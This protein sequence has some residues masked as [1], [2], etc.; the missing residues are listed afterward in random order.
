MGQKLVSLIDSEAA[1]VIAEVL[2][3]GLFL[4]PPLTGI[5]WEQFTADAFERLEEA[6][7]ASAFQSNECPSP[8]PFASNELCRLAVY[9]FLTST[10]SLIA[11]NQIG[12]LEINSDIAAL[13]VERVQRFVDHRGIVRLLRA[14]LTISTF[15]NLQAIRYYGTMKKRDFVHGVFHRPWVSE[16]LDHELRMALD[17]SLVEYLVSDQK[18]PL[19]DE[20]LI[21]LTPLGEQE[22]IRLS[23][24]LSISNYFR[25]RQLLLAVSNFNQI[26]NWD[27]LQAE[28]WPD[29]LRERREFLRAVGVRSGWRIL[30]V[31]I[32]TATLTVDGGLSSLVGETGT[33]TAIDISAAILAQ[34]AEKLSAHKMTN[35]A[36][37]K[38]DVQALPFPD[39]S[40][41]AAL[42][43]GVLHFMK[44]EAALAELRRVTK[45]GGIVATAGPVSFEWDAPF[46]QEWF[47]PLFELSVQEND[48]QVRKR[49]ARSFETQRHFEHVGCR[50]VCTVPIETTWVFK[51]P[52]RATQHMILGVGLFHEELSRLPWHA[53]EEMIQIICERGAHI[54]EKYPLEQRKL[55]IPGEFVIGVA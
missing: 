28:V 15:Y 25:E 6:A 42:G 53:R 29:A 48:G 13:A 39:R 37:V 7:E 4:D 19:A 22:L 41:D 1:G 52:V 38:A 43:F 54:C 2:A 36:L 9:E 50:D 31:G 5:E 34:A 44:F 49:V 33:I 14:Y 8:F 3:A 20:P 40:F 47:A 51:D 12:R 30:E 35:V 46:F 21:R 23:S 55:H 45:S 26:D 10:A 18:V 24:Q 11:H 17:E 27:A 16:P 32:G